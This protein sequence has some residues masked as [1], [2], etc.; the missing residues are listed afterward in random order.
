MR[1]RWRGAGRAF[2]LG[3]TLVTGTVPAFDWGVLA[4]MASAGILGG[5][6]S[7]KLQKKLSS[8]KVDVMFQ[9]LLIIILIICVYNAVRAVA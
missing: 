9:I 7:A 8:E 4:A 2:R 5:L 1:H 3:A 6:L